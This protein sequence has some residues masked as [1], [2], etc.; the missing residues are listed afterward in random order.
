[1]LAASAHQL[2]VVRVVHTGRQETDTSLT[3]DV[4]IPSYVT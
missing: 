4:T 1:M 2:A 3:I